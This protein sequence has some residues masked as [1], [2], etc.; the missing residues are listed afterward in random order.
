MPVQATVIDDTLRHIGAA[1]YIVA[2]ILL[3]ICICRETYFII[4]ERKK[5]ASSRH[6]L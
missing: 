1:I 5:D 3:I 6:Y 4:K 2:F